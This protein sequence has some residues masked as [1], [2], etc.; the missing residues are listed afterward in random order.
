M[1]RPLP[2]P[3]PYYRFITHIILPLDAR[4]TIPCQIAQETGGSSY[5]FIFILCTWKKIILKFEPY[6]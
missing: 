5:F 2:P 1:H 4:W 3:R 6:S